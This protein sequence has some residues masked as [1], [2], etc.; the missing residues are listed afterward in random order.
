MQTKLDCIYVISWIPLDNYIW[1]FCA[2]N[3]L[4]QMSIAAFVNNFWQAKLIARVHMTFYN[5][6]GN[7]KLF[8]YKIF[9]LRSFQSSRNRNEWCSNVFEFVWI[10]SNFLSTKFVVG[11][12]F[13]RSLLSK[14][15]ISDTSPCWKVQSRN[16]FM[17][18]VK[19]MRLYSN[20]YSTGC[21]YAIAW[22]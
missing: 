1:I 19:Q 2:I 14:A 20:F 17:Y 12:C 7:C 15:K 5:W 22:C 21:P 9:M 13:A 8:C 6:R 16:L 18:A 11:N 10:R 4:L 3:F